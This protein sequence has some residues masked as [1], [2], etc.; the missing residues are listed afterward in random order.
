MNKKLLIAAFG[1][2]AILAA[3]CGNSSAPAGAATTLAPATTVPP[4]TTKLPKPDPTALLLDVTEN[5]GCFMMGPNCRHFQ[6]H[7]DGSFVVLR[8]GAETAGAVAA[9][10][11][12]QM[13]VDALWAQ[14]SSANYQLIL[15]SLGPG[16][17]TACYDGIDATL[18]FGFEGADW[19]FNSAEV[20]LDASVP[21]IHAAV[22]AA[23]A[24]DQDFEF[25]AVTR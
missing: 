11:I 19:V 24:M 15:D 20:E 5:G 17:C 1:T 13:V 18:V 3:A 12:D 23:A 22:Q 7:G 16:E 6:L 4:S 21:L 9:G 14:M 8:T 10:S 2:I 25:P